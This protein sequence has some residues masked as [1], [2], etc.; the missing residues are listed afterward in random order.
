MLANS[1][2]TVE[3]ARYDQRL[4]C[5]LTRSRQQAAERIADKRRAPKLQSV[6][7]THA[8]DR[9]HVDA[10]GHGVAALDDLPGLVLGL[11]C[12]RFLG[13]VPTDRGGVKEKLGAAQCGQTR[14][15]GEPLVPTH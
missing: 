2:D 5:F 12:L 6:F 1:V 14:A 3:V 11:S 8:V 7:R 10:I 4:F 15:F 13:M 9:R